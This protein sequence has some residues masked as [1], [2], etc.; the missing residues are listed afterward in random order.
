MK[1]TEEIEE[2]EIVEE[3]QKAPIYIGYTPRLIISIILLPIFSVIAV[4]LLYKAFQVKDIVNIRYSEKSIPTFQVIG[5]DNNLLA[6][7]EDGKWTSTEINQIQLETEYEFQT[8]TDT[9]MEMKY[10]ILADLII[11]EKD[12][13]DKVFF[14]QT[15]EVSEPETDTMSGNRITINE[16][17]TI[18]YEA[19]NTIASQYAESYGVETD[20]FIHFYLKVDYENNIIVNF[21]SF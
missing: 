2:Y 18:P 12:N 16:Q 14:Q 6:P 3:N 4:I 21:G 9:D 7:G 1:K 15:Q 20:S 13:P 10:Q 11:L 8:N 5:L 17:A 19:F